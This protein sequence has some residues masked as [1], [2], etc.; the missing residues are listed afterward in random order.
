MKTCI[1]SRRVPIAAIVVLCTALGC[2]HVKVV[3]GTVRSRADFPIEGATV[4]ATC[5][6]SHASHEVTTTTDES[7]NFLFTITYAPFS[8]LDCVELSVKHSRYRDLSHVRLADS[9]QGMELV[10][11]C[12]SDEPAGRK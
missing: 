10:L 6:E 3:S 5:K 2:D 4:S 8:R 1:Y 12:S 9:G 7:G 11:D